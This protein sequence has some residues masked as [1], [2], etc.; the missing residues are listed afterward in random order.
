MININEFMEMARED[1][2]TMLPKD[3]TKDLTI[4]QNTV[5]KMNDQIFYGLT[6]RKEGEESAPTIYMNEPF[7][8]YMKGE[9]LKLLMAEVCQQY[10]DALVNRPEVVTQD[11]TFER[12][13]D[14]LT[15]RIVEAKRNSAFLRDIPYMNMGNG[16]V[17]ICDVKVVEE[18]SGYWRTTINNGLQ[19]EN[20]Y[21]KREMFKAAIENSQISEPAKMSTMMDQLFGDSDRNLLDIEGMIPENSRDHMYILSNKDGDLGSAAFF[22]PGVREKIA[23]KLGEGF[24][25]LP[26]SVH[27]VLILPESCAPP[28]KDIAEMV[29]EANHS[30]VDPKEVLSD[31]IFH[32]D[33]ETR[34]L[35]TIQSEVAREVRDD[36]VRS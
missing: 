26:S 32:F 31:N 34:R 5:T 23:E 30:V 29:Y 9:P 14:N 15:I 6:L 17:A 20:N 8:R 4:E 35:E 27:E 1:I 7:D 28:I 3:L 2:L 10:L 18:N 25:V 13:K 11:L 36:S 22:Y 33:K 21:D 19:Q 12:I 24:Y 16:F